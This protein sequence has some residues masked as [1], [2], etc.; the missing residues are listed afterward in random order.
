MDFIRKA[1]FV[2]GGHMTETP[3]SLTYSSVVSQESV[4]IAFL[5]ATLNGLDI[6]S[7]DIGNA[8]L[9]APCREHIWFVAGP[10]CGDLQG[11]PCKLIRTLYGLKSSGAAW[12][13]MF[14]TFI[15]ESLSFKP[16]HADPDVYIWLIFWDGQ[17]YYEYLL[18]YVNDVLVV[19]HAPNEVMKGIGEQFEIKNGEYGPPTTYLG[20]GI[21]QVQLS[22]GTMCWSMESHKYVKAAVDTIQNILLEDGREL[23]AGRGS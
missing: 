14:S 20:A 5:I 2:A 23:K 17:P 12:G 16:T 10:K 22:D 3:N 18:V 9:N 1:R 21:S 8:Y 15:V 4:K 6:M 13:A 19:S 7:C 11:L